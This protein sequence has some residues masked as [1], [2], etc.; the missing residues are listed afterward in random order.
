MAAESDPHG[1]DQHAPGAKLDAGKNRLGLVFNGFA[2]ALEQVGWVGTHG[3]E[4]YTP[5]GWREV[6]YGVERYTDA[7]Y[8]HLN[9]EG[10]G[11]ALDPSSHLLHAAHVAWNALAR[12]E[13]KM[14]EAEARAADA[15]VFFWE[16]QGHGQH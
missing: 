16:E 15:G 11:E 1:I 10:K 8:R 3:A 13:L 5:C 12:L 7:M 4:K 2:R 9:A 14:L 6:P